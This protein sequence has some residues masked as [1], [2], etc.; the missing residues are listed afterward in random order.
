MT[1]VRNPAFLL[2]H[3]LAMHAAQRGE[4]DALVC[5]GERR[6]WRAFGARTAAIAAAIRAS[7]VATGAPVAL[8]ASSSI[9]SVEV[10]M[11]IMRA[12]ACIVPVSTFLTPDQL[13]ELLQDSG[14][15]MLFASAEFRDLAETAIEGGDG[16]AC[17]GVDFGGG[18]WTQLDAFVEAAQPAPLPPISPSDRFGMMY[19]SGTTGVPKGIV[20]D[21]AARQYFCVSNALQFGFTRDS[22]A[23]ISTSLFTIGTWLMVLPV[24]FVGG[25]LHI[26]SRFSPEAFLETA[27]AERISHAFVVPTQVAALD[28]LAASGGCESLPALKVLLSA[29]SVLQRGLKDRVEAWLGPVVYELYGFT[30]G[31]STCLAPAD[32]GA[33]ARA[34]DSVGR[35]LPGQE[36]RVVDA[37][38]KVLPAGEAG[39]IVARGPGNMQGYFN[40]PQATAEAIW[41]GADGNEY[42]RSGDIGS[43][44]DDGFVYLI[45]RKKDMVISG[46]L[47]V[48]PAD[49]ERVLAGHP[50]V[51]EAT[52]FGVPDEVWGETP[53][54]MVV[55]G[56]AGVDPASLK[57]W[58]NTRL[59]RHQRVSRIVLCPAFPRNALGKIVKREL[60]D[61]Y[62]KGSFNESK[63]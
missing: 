47:N 59:A 18:R 55:A 30:E 53:V 41:R 52:V 10:M 62:T 36:F 5:A 32:A 9:A 25:A 38:G 15:T 33:N 27:R 48:Y 40:R 50:D 1:T 8:L 13:R 6:S 24:M 28:R 35:P 4:A 63:L 49:I 7:G 44:D 58:L 22:R 26:L 20:H 14:V 39:E 45:D 60:R 56:R 51:A 21:Q 54:A 57:D 31:G 43:L 17:V 42:I 34:R 11:A 16:V 23:L 29:G 2:P 19:S 61:A 3:M 46:G 12:G 37:E